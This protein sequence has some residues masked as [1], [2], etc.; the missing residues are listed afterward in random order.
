MAKIRTVL[1]DISPVALG[2]TNCHDHI[3]CRPPKFWTDKNPDLL[4]VD[5]EKSIQEM[6]FFKE[7]GGQSFVDASTIDYGHDLRALKTVSE[8]TGVH[9]I[10][11]TGF[12]KDRFVEPWVYQ[13]PIE[14][15]VEMVAKEITEGAQGTNVQCGIVKGGSMYNQIS[16]IAD[17]L[18]RIAARVHRMTGAPI[19]THTEMGTMGLEQLDIFDQEGV[20][21]TRVCIG[22]CDLNP[23]PWYAKAIAA[24]GAFVGIDSVG[25]V[26]YH[27]D[28][29]RV[30]VL[31][32]LVNAGY[33][34]Q[35]LLGM[36]IGRQSD[37]KAYQ[38]GIGHGWLLSRFIPRLRAEGFPDEVL[39]C[40]LVENPKR[41]LTF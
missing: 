33:V 2:V 18:L 24:R 29:Q 13:K 1:G 27:P 39:N 19:S 28:S 40:F 38:G 14:E 9:I 20:D 31:H 3:Y 35:V 36:D 7:S 10:A 23:D 11:T 22:H 5:L 17:R 25:K 32:A 34:K 6:N 21:L 12:N 26:K 41:W 4:L 16:P 15:V 37:S 8:R 30:E